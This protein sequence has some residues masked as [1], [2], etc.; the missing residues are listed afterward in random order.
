MANVV[1]LERDDARVRRYEFERQE[2]LDRSRVRHLQ[3]VFEA[4][5]HR[6]G[7]HLGASVRQPA[8]VT[9]A[10]ID[11]VTWEEHA[12]ALPDPT[13]LAAA[14]LLPLEGRFVLHLP[15]P[16]SLQLVDVYLGGDGKSSPDRS[17][18]TDIETRLVSDLADE[19]FASVPLAFNPFIELGLGAIQKASSP[20]FIQAGRPGEVCLRV[21]LQVAVNDEQPHCVHLTIS[22]SA[23]VPILES[24]ERLQRADTSESAA[25]SAK[26]RERLLAVPVDLT[27]G[28]PPI[29][30]SPTELL[31]LRP[32][33]V[34]PLHHAEAEGESALDVM[35]GGV[36]FGRGA[37]VEKGK[38]LALRLASRTEEVR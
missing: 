34:I 31:G 2:A 13:F 10:G 22:L 19:M 12:G 3:P 23:A 15:V 30:L 7:S 26:I 25:P 5:A 36:L 18:L 6:M 33:D 35:V 8:H 4:M 14:T 32:G 1:L 29:G 24:I 37:L 11:Q 21:E 27:V 17:K 9:L 28:Y 16:L 38:R 20:M